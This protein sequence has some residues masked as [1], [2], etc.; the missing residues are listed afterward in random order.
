M[1]VVLAIFGAVVL[2]GGLLAQRAFAKRVRPFYERSCA[3]KLWRERFPAAANG[4]IRDFLNLFVSSFGLNRQKRLTF[5]PDDQVMVIYRV[6]YPSVG[7][8]DALEC[9]TFVAKCR[10]RYGVD[11][12][13]RWSDSLTLG[14]IFDAIHKDA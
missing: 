7:G 12:A 6:I 8:V 9:E 4:E 14:Q 5:S 2:V 3:G 13:S 10:K 1:K 11:L